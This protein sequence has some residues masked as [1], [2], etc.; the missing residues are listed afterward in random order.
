MIPNATTRIITPLLLGLLVLGLL[1]L[2]TPPGARAGTTRVWVSQT[3]KDFDAGT[4]SGVLVTSAGRLVRSEVARRTGLAGVSMVFSMIEAG[5]A[6][7]LGTGNKGE[8]WVVK[9]GRTRKLVGLKGAVLVTCFARGPAGTIYAGTLPE[10]RIYA[11]A[12]ATGTVKQLVQVKAKHVW[13]LVYRKGTLFAAT[14][15][16]GQLFAID[17]AGR[18]R[19]YW[20]SKEAHLQS[21]ATGPGGDLYVGTAPKAIVYRVLGPRRVRALHDFAGNE[22]RALAGDAKRLYVAVNLI[23]PDRSSMMRF[24]SWAKPK[25]T[26]IKTRGKHMRKRKRKRKLPLPR[27]GAKT[28]SGGL[29]SLDPSGS[30]TQLYS[31]KKGYFTALELVRGRLYAA[32]GTRG[33]VISI[34]PDESAATAHDVKE[35]QVLALSLGGRIR[36]FGTG[37]GAALYRVGGRGKNHYTSGAYDTTNASGFGVIS[38]RSSG[39]V[40]VQTRSGNTATPDAGWSRWQPVTP[41]GRLGGFQRGLVRSPA[42]RY[43]QYRIGWPGG[44]RAVVHHV[45]LH[46]TAINRAPRWKYLKV[47]DASTG[48]TPVQKA[49][50]IKNKKTTT[51]A[52]EELKIS[53]KVSDPD[54]DPLL[55]RVAF[56]AVGDVRWRKIGDK[57]HTST[58]LKWRTDNLPDG[59]YEIRVTASDERANSVTRSRSRQRT[60][61]PVLVDHNK[62]TFVGLRVRGSIATG[63]VRDSYSRIT[64]IAYSTDGKIWYQVDAVD[65]N[66]DQEAER[67]SFRLP[68]LRPGVHTLLVR[69]YDAAG[70]AQV[71]KHTLRIR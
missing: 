36:A 63:L 48:K 20:D 71:V 30:A 26:K 21:I 60:S 39:R 11:I 40:T 1:L 13:G 57:T 41:K 33:R 35:R 23:K 58:S 70:N 25:G 56:R 19:V 67:F 5:G 12:T 3:Y 4:P 64:G 54:G 50:W 38:F 69:A 52:P 53:W 2:A 31:V 32:E 46:F 44:S 8:I 15:P 42:G 66:F 61:V 6:L 14:G 28:G 45:R 68:K 18:A 10:G 62:P 49:G 55:Y 43:V 16:K 17:R 37:D 59:W 27:L 9:G 34:L 22:I 29:F 47:G 65:G 24:P 7:Y 51:A